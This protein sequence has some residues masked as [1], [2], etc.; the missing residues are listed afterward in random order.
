MWAVVSLVCV[1]TSFAQWS[2]QDYNEL[3]HKQY[4]AGDYQWAVDNLLLALKLAPTS[5]VIKANLADCYRK[6]SYAYYLKGEFPQSIEY[7]KKILALDPQNAT[8]YINIWLSYIQQQKFQKALTAFQKGYELSFKKEE[9]EAA[10]NFINGAKNLQKEQFDPKVYNTK[11]FFNYKQYYLAGLNVYNAWKKLPAESGRQ[12]VKIAVVDEGVDINHPDLTKNIRTNNKEIPWNGKD[13][14][15]NGYKDDY[16]GWNFVYNNNSL[17]PLWNH[18]T[19]VAGIIAAR[20]DN[21]EWIAWIVPYVKIMP[22]WVLGNGAWIEENIIK[23]IKYAINNGAHIIN[24]SLGWTQFN[25]TDRFDAVIK[26]ANAS[27]VVVIIA[28]GNG[29]VLSLNTKGVNTDITKLSPVCNE[30]KSKKLIIWVWALDKKWKK[31]QWSNYGKCVD[32]YAFGEDV[33]STSVLDYNSFY[34]I[35]YS[36][37]NGTSFSAP[38]VAGIV[39]LGFNKYGKVAPDKVYQAL[40]QSQKKLD[41]GTMTLDAALYLD[42]LGKLIK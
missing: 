30:G 3:A 12:L 37:D 34:G 31:T 41:N 17:L 2:A 29:D 38:M 23:G 26:Q 32:V 15:G 42:N 11:D 33:F 21:E 36:P 39:W 14:D 9:I 5:E 13:D 25:Y 20:T 18:G 27:G 8:A 19:K 40:L 4:D 24:L 35:Q 7:S 28:A 6:L 1:S 16:N 10:K 22:I